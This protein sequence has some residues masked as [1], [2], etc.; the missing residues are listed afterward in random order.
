MLVNRVDARKMG[1]K[2]KWLSK[3]VLYIYCGRGGPLGNKYRM[4]HE[5]ERERCCLNCWQ[6]PSWCAEA[7]R[8]V[9]WVVAQN[10]RCKCVLLGC[11]CTDNKMCHTD[12]LRQMLEQL[13]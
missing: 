6:D 3:N 1:M 12:K 5:S 11:F 13:P 8:L 10:G 7:Q 9:E 4:H 2:S